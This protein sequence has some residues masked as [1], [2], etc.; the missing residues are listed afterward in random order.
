MMEAD[1]GEKMSPE[2]HVDGREMRAENERRQQGEGR[3]RKRR[4][5]ALKGKGGF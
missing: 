1:E 2:A 3:K 5:D 4:E